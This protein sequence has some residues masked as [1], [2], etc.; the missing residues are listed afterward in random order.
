VVKKLLGKLLSKRRPVEMLE[1]K[2]AD[3][4]TPLKRQVGEANVRISN[5]LNQLRRTKKEGKELVEDIKDTTESYSRKITGEE[6]K[7][8]KMFDDIEKT[9]TD[10]ETGQVEK[11]SHGGLVKK[12]FPKL[13][14]KG[15]K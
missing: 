9:V 2:P 6:V 4:S 11:Y 8:S 15:W 14:K 3:R 5:M 7:P 13:T 10:L 12:G 1:V